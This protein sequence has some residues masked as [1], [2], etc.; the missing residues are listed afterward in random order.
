MAALQS[1]ITTCRSHDRDNGSRP[2]AAE[3]E[4]PH[5]SQYRLSNA[6][7]RSPL[8][9]T[10]GSPFRKKTKASKALLDFSGLPVKVFAKPDPD[11]WNVRTL[12]LNVGI[13]E[14]FKAVKWQ[15]YTDDLDM[16]YEVLKGIHPNM[17]SNIEFA[18]L[19]EVKQALQ[20]VYNVRD[21]Q[22]HRVWA[23]PHVSLISGWFYL[24]CLV[25]PAPYIN[26]TAATLCAHAS[27]R[28]TLAY[29]SHSQSFSRLV[30][31]SL[32]NA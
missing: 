27:S 23:Q 22:W 25:N 8:K 15:E 14:D 21:E 17:L 18:E 31:Q 29:V 28:M 20:T 9:P 11:R 3:F 6:L 10:G 13:E 4:S 7:Q 12:G 2:A 32:W 30:W 1:R 19:Q 26:C 16:Q 24:L 5:G